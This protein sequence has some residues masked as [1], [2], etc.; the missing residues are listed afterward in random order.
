MLAADYEPPQARLSQHLKDVRL[1]L[2]AAQKTT[3]KTPLK[4]LHEE[5]LALAESRGY[6]KA[7]Y[8]KAGYGKADNAAIIEAYRK[9][10]PC[11]D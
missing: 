10:T 4:Q 7:G 1:M 2:A 11:S 6:G 8:G 5:L 3:A 9:D